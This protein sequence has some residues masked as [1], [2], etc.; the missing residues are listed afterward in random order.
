MPQI[1]REK[2]EKANIFGYPVDV[3]TRENA[4]NMVLSCMQHRKGL[5]VVTINPEMIA[6]A[7]KNPELATILKDAGLVIPDS[8]GIMLALKSL[9]I[10]KA[11]KIP[12]IEFSEKLM[13]KCEEKG[14]KVAFLGG[15]QETVSSMNTE[16]QREFPGLNVV[17]SCH[18]YFKEDELF[19]IH[20]ELVK[21]TPHLLFVALG[22]PGQ[23]FFIKNTGNLLPETTMIGVGGSF[24]VWAK[25]V[26]RAPLVFRK[27]GLE[28]FYRLITQPFRFK[29]MFPALPL[30]FL[31]I[32]FDRR[33]LAQDYRVIADASHKL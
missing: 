9:G 29:R 28:W 20:E 14:Y 16:I 31:R 24:D 4:L 30:F 32:A 19:K 23:E 10:K 22:S 13:K 7:D 15:T 21:A 27:S 26:K 5:H 1:L 25:K 12:G 8:T 11:E 6:A 18:G 2:S 17:F 3:T 33:N